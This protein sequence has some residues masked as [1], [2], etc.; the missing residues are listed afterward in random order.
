MTSITER[1]STELQNKSFGTLFKLNWNKFKL[2]YYNFRMLNVIKG[3]KCDHKG[4]SYSIYMKGYE[5]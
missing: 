2:E 5:R 3:V 1:G 4:N